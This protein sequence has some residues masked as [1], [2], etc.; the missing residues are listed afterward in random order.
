MSRRTSVMLAIA[1]TFIAL[2]GS[3]AWSESEPAQ[4]GPGQEAS[5]L[6]TA[7]FFSGGLSRTGHFPGK[8][9]CLSCDVNPGAAA[10]AQCQK[11]GHRHALKIEGDPLLHP[12][13]ASEETILTRINSNELHGREVVVSGVYYPA[14]GAIL[15]SGVETK[16]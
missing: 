16:G 2:L 5:L 14:T 10:K 7:T 12:L 8:L 13:L 1:A 4:P 6:R 3:A 15:V 11:S 9:V